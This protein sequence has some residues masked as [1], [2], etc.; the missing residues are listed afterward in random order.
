[1]YSAFAAWG[2][3]KHPSSRKSSREAG[4]RGSRMTLSSKL[5]AEAK[6]IRQNLSLAVAQ[7]RFF[8]QNSTHQGSK[9]SSTRRGSARTMGDIVKC[10]Q[11]AQ[12]A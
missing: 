10:K 3:S 11:N 6:K 8:T 5:I 12:W 2:C 1:M 4:G 7:R 9:L